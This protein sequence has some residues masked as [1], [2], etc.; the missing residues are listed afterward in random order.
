MTQHEG[1]ARFEIFKD[2]AGGF[3]WRLVAATGETVA[4][5]ERYLLKASVVASARAVQMAAAEAAVQDLRETVD[6][7]AY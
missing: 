6:F 1:T 5:S 2:D 4:Q 3:H 7:D